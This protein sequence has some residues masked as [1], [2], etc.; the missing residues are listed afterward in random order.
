[1]ASIQKYIDC[2]EAER[3]IQPGFKKH[4]VTT[5][6]SQ[7]LSLYMKDPREAVKAQIAQSVCQGALRNQSDSASTAH[8]MNSKIGTAAC[9]AVDS[10]VKAKHCP[11]VI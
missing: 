9:R 5:K 10:A 8:S 4:N 6:N 1:M 2:T 11:R 7:E 3:I